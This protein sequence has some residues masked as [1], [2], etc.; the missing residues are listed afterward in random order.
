MKITKAKLKQIILEELSDIEGEDVEYGHFATE[1][2]PRGTSEPL[3]MDADVIPVSGQTDP[4]VAAIAKVEDVGNMIMANYPEERE[5]LVLVKDLWDRLQG[6]L[7]VPS[8]EVPMS[9][10]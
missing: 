9:R 2:D 6:M 1:S 8:N 4:V 7:T 3:T 5:S 10:Q